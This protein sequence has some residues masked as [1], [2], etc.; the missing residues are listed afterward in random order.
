MATLSRAPATKHTHKDAHAYVQQGGPQTPIRS[1]SLRALEDANLNPPAASS[2]ELSP[3]TVQ[4]MSDLRARK[5]F[6]RVHADRGK[7]AANVA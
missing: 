4:L 3:A 7:Q 2:S 1:Q 6:L 5:A